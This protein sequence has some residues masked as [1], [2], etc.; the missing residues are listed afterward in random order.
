MPRRSNLATNSKLPP[1]TALH[2][3]TRLQDEISRLKVR[4]WH[5]QSICIWVDEVK[6]TLSRFYGEQST[7]WKQFHQI[8]F[9][10][11]SPLTEISDRRRQTAFQRKLEQANDFL[12]VCIED[13]T[14]G[15]SYK[16]S[17]GYGRNH[18]S[19][20]RTSKVFLVHGH[21]HGSKEMVARYLSKLGLEPIILHEQPD[22]GRT[23]IEKFEHHSDVS[24]AIAILTADDL[25]ASKDEPEK[26]ESRARQNVIFEL[27]F[28]IG[29]LGRKNTF[30]LL[31]KGVSKPSDMDGVL[32]LPMDE[33]TWRLKLVGELKAAGLEVDAN[34]AF[35]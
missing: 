24:C 9:R 6:L 25:A 13:L 16:P 17:A 15:M 1:K 21:D 5:D 19:D 7:E 33:D 8:R 26:Q 14:D 30:A 23:I 4:S 32:Y 35:S 27:G 10:F 28:F 18:V 11:D 12:S 20:S 3:L 2:K 29:Y 22:Q 34:K 31:Q